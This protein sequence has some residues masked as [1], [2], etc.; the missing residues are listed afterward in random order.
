MS[1]SLKLTPMSYQWAMFRRREP[2]A[3]RP[4]PARPGA[5]AQRQAVRSLPR[6]S[7]PAARTP[8]P[9]RS[10]G[11]GFPP[12]R[13]AGRG[14]RCRSTRLGSAVFGPAGNAGYR[15][16]RPARPGPP[17]GVLTVL[18]V[19]IVPP[20]PVVPVYLPHPYTRCPPGRRPVAVRAPGPTAAARRNG[21]RSIGGRGSPVPAGLAAPDPGTPPRA[22]RPGQRS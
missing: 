1:Y 5:D 19:L 13:G 10:R 16:A 4:F 22:R 15:S 18:A 11:P 21:R 14:P 2:Q 20:V 7:A 6:R 9:R 3:C 12:P 17:L 8:A